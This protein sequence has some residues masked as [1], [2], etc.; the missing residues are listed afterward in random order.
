LVVVNSDYKSTSVSLLDPTT[1]ALTHDDCI[2]SGTTAPAL[3]LSLS[4][5]VV[6]PSG[7]H[8]EHEVLLI[9]RTNSALTW[10]N[11]ETC[12]VKRQLAVGTGFYA[13]PNDVVTLSFNK[14][15][16]TRYERNEQPTADP[17]DFDEGDDLLIIDPTDLRAVA[18][19]PLG[20]HAAEV[21][22]QKLQARP[23]HAVLAGDKIY[24]S[25]ANLS[26]DFQ[27]AGDGRIAVVD[28]LS[29]AVAGT[30]DLPGLKGCTGLDYEAA[31]KT[32]LVT[33]TG[34]FGDGPMQADHSGL[35]AIDVGANPPAVKSTLAAAALQN[36]P[37]SA[38]APVGGQG[39]GALAVTYGEAMGPPPD[40]LWSCDL[41][42]KT[43]AALA[44]AQSSYTYGSLLS[45]PERNQVFLLDGAMD[46]PRVHRFDVA[47]APALKAS[48]DAN[49]ARGLPPRAIGWY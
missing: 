32:L 44:S 28:T 14:A 9:D 34:S 40:Q 4:G 3:S 7:V 48:L 25:L 15:Y 49:P 36:R 13:N 30:I 2:N 8:P 12:E 39:G 17:A 1:F 22:G 42:G 43:C 5:D 45:D 37:L 27:T 29:D 16:V 47:G 11:P 18:R 38:A 46:G 6:V 26:S 21:N 24:V 20:D 31:S 33:C 41:T 35:V 19:I 10:L 23:S